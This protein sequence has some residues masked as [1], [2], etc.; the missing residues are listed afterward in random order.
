MPACQAATQAQN[1]YQNQLI[2]RANLEGTQRKG[3]LSDI[4][5]ASQAHNPHV[6]PYNTV[7]AP[8][9][10]QAYMNAID[11]LQQQGSDQLSK[12]PTFTSA[13]LPMPTLTQPP[14]FKQAGTLERVGNWLG[15]ALSLYGAWK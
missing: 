5:K 10:S 4:Y 14:A 2:A 13:N 11:A 15:P 1:A 3:N 8:V 9:L 12:A 6:S 7:G